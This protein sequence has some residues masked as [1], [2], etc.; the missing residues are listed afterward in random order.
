MVKQ[1][2]VQKHLITL[3]NEAEEKFLTEFKSGN[4]TLEKPLV[5]KNPYI[6]NPL[7]AVICFKTD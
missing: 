4:Y 2:E 1:L 3:Q 7:A 6:L 5:I